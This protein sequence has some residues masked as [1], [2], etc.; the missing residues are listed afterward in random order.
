V[1][2]AGGGVLLGL[3]VLDVVVHRVPTR[4]YL[5][6]CVLAAVLL[7]GWGRA[8]GL[9]WA[10]LGV[11][12]PVSGLVWGVAAAVIV[13]LVVGVGVRWRRTRRLFADDR[14]ASLDS[15]SLLWETG[16]RLPVGTV[17]MAEVAFRGLL[18][19]VVAV[20]RSE[21]TAGVVSAVA[22]GLWHVIPSLGRGTEVGAAE[23]L[24][25]RAE[26]AFVVGAVL[27]TAVA[28]LFLGL[29]RIVSGSLLAP[30]LL[31]WA[32]NAFGLLAGWGSTRIP[33]SGG[34]PPG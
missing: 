6:V 25:H 3:I 32:L 14:S 10:Q 30:M 5:P 28:G 22:F 2:L 18:L 17:L 8:L 23:R 11:G 4:L 31:H 15:R 26:V 34:P 7:L 12:A 9:T 29:L 20:N 33:G 16:V 13:A 27:A 24:G 21:V 19:G 1:G